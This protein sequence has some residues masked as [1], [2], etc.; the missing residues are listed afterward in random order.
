[1]LEVTTDKEALQHVNRHNGAIDLFVS[2]VALPDLRGTEAAL[3][4]IQGHAGLRIRLLS[5]TSIAD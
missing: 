2:D 3:R 1:M 5:G 4:L